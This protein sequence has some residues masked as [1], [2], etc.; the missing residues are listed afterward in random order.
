MIDFIIILFVIWMV[1]GTYTIAYYLGKEG[2]PYKMGYSFIHVSIGLFLLL[3]L[4]YELWFDKW[5]NN[6]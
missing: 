4:W 5:L 1:I 3:F 2:N 6:D